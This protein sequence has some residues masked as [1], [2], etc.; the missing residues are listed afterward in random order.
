MA[1]GKVT[2]AWSNWARS[3]S[4]PRRLG[5]WAEDGSEKLDTSHGF[6]IAEM[7]YRKPLL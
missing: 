4:A 1:A 3:R 6:P 2:A 7:R 5:G